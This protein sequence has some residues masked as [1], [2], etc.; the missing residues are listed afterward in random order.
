MVETFRFPGIPVGW[1]TVATSEE[2]RAGQVLPV[3]YFAEE[4]ILYRTE[5]GEARLTDA[6]CPHMGAHLGAGKVEG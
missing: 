4:L 5:S 6:Y 3:K 2:L 1:Y